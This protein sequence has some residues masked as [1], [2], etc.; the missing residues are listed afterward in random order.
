MSTRSL[1]VAGALLLG[2]ATPAIA[3][4][5][6]AVELGGFGRYTKFDSDLNFDNKIGVGGRF[7]IFLA[8]NL[9]VEADASYTTTKSAGGA[10]VHYIPV[11]AG[12]TYNVPVG[13]AAAFLL[14]GRYVRNL[15]R[16]AYRETSSGVGGL[17]GIR[18]GTSGPVSLRIEGTVDYIPTAESEAVPPQ[19]AG[20]NQAKSN[21]HLGAQAGL[22]LLLGAKRDNDKDKDGVPNR[23]D[24]CPS[25]PLG[26]RV[27]A[28]GCTLPK[29]ADH[30]GVVDAQDRCPGTPA[31]TPVDATG[32]SKDKDGD[33]V[34]DDQDRC[35][36]TP[37][38]TAV[39]AS[40]CPRDSDGDGV[41]DPDDKCPNTP[42]GA[43]VDA[44]GCPKDTDRDGVTDTLDKCPNTPAGTAVDDTGCPRDSDG[45]GVGNVTDKCPNTP[46]G[47]KVDATGCPALFVAGP[48]LVLQGVNFETGRATLLPESMVTLDRVAASLN[49]LPDVS[50]EVSGHTD[51]KGGRALNMRLSEARAKS[52]RDY[53]ISKGVD[54][55]RITAK[56]YGPDKPLQSNATVDGRAANR[57]VELSRTN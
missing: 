17:A 10:D 34:S 33:G 46:A 7:G 44:T 28:V 53:L 36:N 26:D 42:A 19:L 38:G 5:A 35:P 6:G 52:V 18:I 14:G 30:D 13:G 56:G 9:A 40:G 11:H 24:K 12:L 20:I 27:D 54:G 51:S 55:A 16:S 25:T 50:V 57:R 29:D 8:S 47:L 45:D 48:R 37:A 41:L 23:V 43:P 3:Q 49:N 22:S 2:T 15:F 1:I 31:G 21:L 4:K 39:N 32:C